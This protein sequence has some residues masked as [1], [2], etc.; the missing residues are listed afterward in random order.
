MSRFRDIKD[1]LY[2]I[3]TNFYDIFRQGHSMTSWKPLYLLQSIEN[4]N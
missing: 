1:L 4:W 3:A 2:A